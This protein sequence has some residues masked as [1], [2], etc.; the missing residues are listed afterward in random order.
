MNPISTILIRED[1]KKKDY[2]MSSIKR[3]GG[4]HADITISLKEKCRHIIKIYL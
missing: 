3:V 2:L 4:Y 1:V